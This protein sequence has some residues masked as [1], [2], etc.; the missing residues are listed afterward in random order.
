MLDSEEVTEEEE[1]ETL[2][3]QICE[4]T[5]D[6]PDDGDPDVMVLE[7]GLVL[8]STCEIENYT[9]CCVC[10]EYIHRHPI[11][12]RHLFETDWGDW[13]GTGGSDMDIS[14]YGE[15]RASLEHLLDQM[16]WR[17]AIDLART[18]KHNRMDYDNLHTVTGL[19]LG[20]T[21]VFCYLDRGGRTPRGWARPGSH[22]Y[23]DQI[24]EVFYTWWEEDTSDA[25]EP[26]FMY[27]FQWL[28]G[29]GENT[30]EENARTLCWIWA[31]LGKRRE[32][33]NAR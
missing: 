18:I 7:P 21:M 14:A 30:P 13:W 12:H 17:F 5:N 16:G 20:P 26:P 31:W 25:D 1:Q 4:K 24:G 3:C 27:G 8:C 15:I 11:N 6:D 22:S 33:K 19:V 32:K 2:T 10:Q 29:L 23:G 9:Y 28:F